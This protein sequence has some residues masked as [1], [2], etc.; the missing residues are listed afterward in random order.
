M[1]SPCKNP[2]MQNAQIWL[3]SKFLLLTFFCS[4][5]ASAQNTRPDAEKELAHDIYKQFI[6]IPS[7]FTTGS[8]TPVAEAAAARLKAAGFSDSDIFL[9]GANP[10]KENIV[11]RYHGTGKRRPILLLAHTD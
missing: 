1:S 6:E 8:T 9:G 11:V 3:A 2:T 4:A 5:S 7:G 10:K